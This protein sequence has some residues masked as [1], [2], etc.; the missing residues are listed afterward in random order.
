MLE[1][2]SY[3]YYIPLP[4]PK[5]KHDYV[6]VNGEKRIRKDSLIVKRIVSRKENEMELKATLQIGT[7]IPVP[8]SVIE[9]C[10]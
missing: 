4:S 6:W 3:K 10:K 7:M 1:I 5:E 9:L 8:D 2:N